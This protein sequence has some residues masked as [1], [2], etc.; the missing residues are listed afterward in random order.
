M[1]WSDDISVSVSVWFTRSFRHKAFYQAEGFMEVVSIK[2]ITNKI[3]KKINN[4]V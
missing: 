2:E 4:G 1:Y 3:V